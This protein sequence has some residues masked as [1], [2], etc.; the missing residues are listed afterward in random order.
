MSPSKKSDFYHVLAVNLD[1]GRTLKQ[2][3]GQYKKGAWFDVGQTVVK[4]GG[5]KS[6]AERFSAFHQFGAFD[7][8]MIRSGETSG[9]LA[10]IFR[11]LADYYAMM[12]EFRKKLTSG[13]RYPIFLLHFAALALA[14]PTAAIS[15]IEPAARDVFKYLAWFYAGGSVLWLAGATLYDAAQVDAKAES[16]I[17]ALPFVGRIWKRT[18][19]LRFAYI[20]Q[21]MIHSNIGI[22][23]AISRAG[24]SSGSPAILGDAIRMSR[25]IRSENGISDSLAGKNGFPQI[26]VDAFTTGEMTGEYDSEMG[27]AAKMLSSKL[28]D[29]I[30]SA[31]RGFPQIIYFAVA[32]FVA[33]K[34]IQS[35]SSYFETV[36]SFL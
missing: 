9:H 17:R 13:L 21:M 18:A 36:R 29:A 31:A 3:F 35:V 7:I 28:Q 19:E 15:G 14:A 27:R 22:I 12:A 30:D 24:S 33:W 10:D 8:E 5:T 1:A 26:I 20:L 2:A 4:T 11:H 16:V 34:V 6:L 32:G 25:D 23:D